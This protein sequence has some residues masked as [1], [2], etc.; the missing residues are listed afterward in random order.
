M[1]DRECAYLLERC[2]RLEARI[3]VLEGYHAAPLLSSGRRRFYATTPA[4]IAH[5]REL[6]RR[7]LIYAEIARRV[8]RS[9]CTARHYTKDVLIEREACYN[10]RTD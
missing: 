6:R 8:S 9:E 5:M 4:E 1:T 7:G 10:E 2:L 3:A